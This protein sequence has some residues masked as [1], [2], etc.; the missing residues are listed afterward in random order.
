LLEILENTRKTKRYMQWQFYITVVLVV[1]PLL[2]MVFIIPM[3]LNNLTAV[4]G[5]MLQ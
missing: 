5:G 1:L 2:A 3:V 4:Y